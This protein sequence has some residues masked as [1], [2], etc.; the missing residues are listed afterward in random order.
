[1]FSDGRVEEIRAGVRSMMGGLR[2]R[3]PDAEGSVEIAAGAGTLVLGHTRLAIL[4]LTDGS[5][6]PMQHAETGSWLVYNGEIYNFRELRKK[7]EALGVRFQTSGDTEVL[8]H[9]LVAWFALGSATTALLY[10]L[11]VPV[12]KGLRAELQRSSA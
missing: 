2:H 12:L 4:D 5:R 9:A 11:L 3:G 8:L 1:M 10:L 7:L 6:Q